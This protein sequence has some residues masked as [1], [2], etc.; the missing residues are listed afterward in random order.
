MSSQLTRWVETC[1]FGIV[2]SVCSLVVPTAFQYTKKATAWLVQFT[3]IGNA[4]ETEQQ[5]LQPDPPSEAVRP[6]VTDWECCDSILQHQGTPL[7]E[8]ARGGHTATAEF[9][10]KA[11]ADVKAINR[12]RWNVLIA[13]ISML[14]SLAVST[15]F[16]CIKKSAACL[17]PFY[18][19]QCH[20]YR[21]TADATTSN[22]WSCQTCSHRF[23]VF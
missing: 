5:E 20:W 23:T 7:H 16:Q 21:P 15:A 18:Y 4:I 3:T 14:C 11:G 2:W 1:W 22:V 12:V 10:L 13:I 9:L 19:R 8:A 6:S 17:V